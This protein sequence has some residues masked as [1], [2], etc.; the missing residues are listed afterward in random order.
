MKKYVI[1]IDVGGTNVK[2]GIAGPSARII[3]RSLLNTK[4]FISHKS[5]L[6]AAIMAGVRALAGQAG[7]SFRDIAGIGIGLPGLV[8]FDKGLVIFLPNIPGWRKVP[9]KRMIQN[10]LGLPVFLENDVNLITLGEWQYGAGKGTRNML[11]MTLGTGVGGGLI[12]DGRLYRGEGFVAGEIGHMPLNETGPACNC[13]GY[14]CFERSVGN[15]ALLKKAAVIFRNKNIT[16]EEITRRAKAGERRSIAFWED[17][18]GHLGNGLVGVVNL[19]NPRRIVIGG[20]VANCPGFVFRIV[21]EILR[22][23]AM[24]VQA[25][26]VDVVRAS[27]GNDAGILGAQVLVR[28]GGER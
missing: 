4:S 1:G 18:A 25:S 14:G 26:M 9:L 10:E 19:L 23:R 12:L 22:E 17:F 13:G 11:C 24:R 6:I 7:V 15:L 3:A 8:D 5:R 2:L 16:L 28:S 21:K 20:G 27:L